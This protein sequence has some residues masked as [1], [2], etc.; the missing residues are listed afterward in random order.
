MQQLARITFEL[1]RSETHDI[2][3]AVGQVRGDVKRIANILLTV[4]DTPLSGVHSTYLG[5]Y[6]SSTSYEALK[7]WLTDLANA[8]SGA[9][10]EDEASQR[11]IRHFVQWA[12]GLNRTEKDLL[13]LAI[14]KKSHFTFDIIHWIGHI[15]KLLLALSNAPACNDHNRDKL[16]RNALSLISVFSW[17]PDEQ[18]TMI[19]VENYQMTETLFEVAID[20]Q[21]RDCNDI[22]MKINNLL[23]SWI[24]K[25]G[26][27][28]TGW[29]ILERG[30]YGLATLNIVMELDDSVLVNSIVDRL[31]KE[32]APSSDIRF[33]AAED[34]RKSA[35]NLYRDLFPSSRIEAA[36]S[37]VDQDRLRNLLH[38]IAD[39]L[40][41]GST[42]EQQTQA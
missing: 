10:A 18:E 40:S 20:A 7:V 28:Q 39:V 14:E 5:P 2:R 16:R 37:Q 3:F 1:I 42:S 32:G 19:F 11:V 12:E 41:P 25:A 4:P 13:L 8:V 17:I 9:K 33:R 6:Y 15:T 22:A 30:I 21:K 23:F 38:Q 35:R 26:K 31:A 34:M 29:G 24:F 36:M 27:Y